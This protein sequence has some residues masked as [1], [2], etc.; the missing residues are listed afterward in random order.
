MLTKRWEPFVNNTMAQFQKEMNRLFDTFGV[1]SVAWPTLAYSYPPVNV[2]EEGDK[3]YA[4]AELPGLAQDQIQVFVTDGNQL[5]ITGERPLK[6]AAENIW[7]RQERGHGKFSRVI[8]LPVAVDADKVEARF[9]HGV[10]HLTLPKSE[11][12]KPRRIQVKAQ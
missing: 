3:L 1:G 4:E 10:L 8:T 2:W 12:A 7:H 6:E 11:H 5:T 9:E